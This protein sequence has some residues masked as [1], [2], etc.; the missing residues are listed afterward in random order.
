M[1]IAMLL[2]R[3]AAGVA[4][5][6][7]AGYEKLFNPQL[8]LDFLA[9]HPDLQIARE[10]GIGLSNVQFIRAAGAIEVLFGLLLISGALPQVIVLVAAVPFTSTLWL[11]GVNELLGHLP[12][13]GAMLVI[14][15]YGSHPQLRRTVYSF[16]FSADAPPP[17]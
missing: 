11:F 14:L 2:L 5:I 12:I 3:V 4:L 7:V 16:R 15:I 9:A 17:G 1:G 8:A 10:L 13:Y 6:A